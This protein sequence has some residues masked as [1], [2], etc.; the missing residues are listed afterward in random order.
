MTIFELA[1]VDSL[2]RA[3]LAEDVGRGDITTRLTVPAGVRA[4]A[5]LLAKQHGVLAGLPLVARVYA[6]IS[7]DVVVDERAKDGDAS[8]F[9]PWPLEGTHRPTFCVWELGAVWHEQQAWSRFL[10]SE[11]GEEEREA[12]LHDSFAGE[13]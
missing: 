13:V 2:L 1:Q 5:T 6:L 11:R 3:A 8:G 10:R 12:Y 4:T 9:H 7:P